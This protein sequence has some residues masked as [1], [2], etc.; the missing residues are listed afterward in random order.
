MADRGAESVVLNLALALIVGETLAPALMTT[1][2]FCS[3]QAQDHLLPPVVAKTSSRKIPLG[4][5]VL[6]AVLGSLFLI[7]AVFAG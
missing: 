4:A 3:A 7:R 5:L 6:I 2:R 1:S